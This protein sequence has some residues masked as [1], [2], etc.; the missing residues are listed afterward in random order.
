MQGIVERAHIRV[1]FVLQVA[2]QKAQLLPSF[3]SRPGQDDPRH[4]VGA[5]GIDGHGDS[6]EGLAGSSWADG[7]GHFVVPDGLD[8]LALAKGLALDRSTLGCDSN[9]IRRIVSDLF[10]IAIPGGVRQVGHQLE[11][12][13]MVFPCQFDQP[14]QHSHG[15][16]Q[17]QAITR[18]RK[19]SGD[20]FD[21]DP[22]HLF[23]HIKMAAET[24][25]DGLGDFW[26]V[27]HQ[28]FFHH[29]FA[30]LR[31]ITARLSLAST[32]QF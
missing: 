19:A 13:W 11:I 21:P 29:P 12:D 15:L 20:Q 4:I 26:P 3:D 18:N 30:T 17:I 23:N 24:A 32:S 22:Q 16:L 1:D 8:V 28:L 2:W 10:Q 27:H 31:S 7:K 14:L 25:R 5:E 6:E 9:R